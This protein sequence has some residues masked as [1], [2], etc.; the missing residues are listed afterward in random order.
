MHP[1]FFRTPEEL[2]EISE[3]LDEIYTLDYPSLPPVDHQ[4]V[5]PP[6]LD[7]PQ[8]PILASLLTHGSKPALGRDTNGKGPPVHITSYES[9]TDECDEPSYSSRVRAMF[10][11]LK[12]TY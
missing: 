1:A 2:D 3:E 5:L 12:S 11:L 6:V 4:F 8:D 10:Y 9:E 7:K